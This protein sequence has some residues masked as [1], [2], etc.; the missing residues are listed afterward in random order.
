MNFDDKSDGDRHFSFWNI[1]IIF[2]CG[3]TQDLPPR[4]NGWFSQVRGHQPAKSTRGTLVTDCGTNW[5]SFKPRHPPRVTTWKDFLDDSGR[6]LPGNS[7]K[8]WRTCREFYFQ[9]GRDINAV[10]EPIKTKN[11]W[12]PRAIIRDYHKLQQIQLGYVQS[13]D[14]QQ[15]QM[16]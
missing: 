13:W 12:H 9:P 2:H 7:N 15:H 5:S 11:V 6:C 3:G 14:I 10:L 4:E 1:R 16:S 8:G